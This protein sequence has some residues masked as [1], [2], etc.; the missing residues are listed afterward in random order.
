VR[1]G[2]LGTVRAV[3]REPFDVVLV[4]DAEDVRAVV[5]RQLRLSGRFDVVGVGGTGAEAIS[6]AGRHRPAVMVLDAS[7][8]DMDGLEALPGV[9]EASPDTKVVMLSGFTGPALETAA[10]A[11]GAVDFVE[12]AVPLRELPDRLLRLLGAT[13]SAEQSATAGDLDD[14]GA[15]EAVLAQ[16]LER[17]GTVFDQAAIGM[18]TMTLSGTVVRANAALAQL[19]GRPERALAG[20]QYAELAGSDD[21]GAALR[22]AVARLS[23]GEI[24]VAGTEH[25]L[26]GGTG[27]WVRST[28][29][30]VADPDGRPLYLFAQ[31]EDVTQRRRALEELQASEERFRL[32]VDSVTDY[33]IFMLDQEGLVTS[34]NA[35][36]ERMKGYRADEVIGQHFRIFYPPEQQAIGH[37]EH[38]LELTVRDGRYEEEGWRV[39]QDGTRFWAN[40][41]ITALF[42]PD[43]HLVGFGKVTRDMTERR[44]AEEQLRAA[45]DEA[46]NVVDITAHELH[47]PIAA[48]TGAA[49][50]LA[51]YWDRLEPDER[52][53][54]MRNLRSSAA[55]ARRLLDDLL[56]ASR[57]EAGSI[58]FQTGDLPL[59]AAIGE[60]IAAV[61]AAAGPVDVVGAAGVTVVADPTRL[62]QMLT[63]LL[64]NAARYGAAPVVVE[65]RPAGSAVEVRVCDHGPGIPDDLEPRLFRKFVRGKGRP[66]RG[67]GLGLFIVAEMARRQHGQV[68]YERR[69]GRTCFGFRLPSGR[70]ASAD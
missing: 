29:A 43:H 60:A 53:E 46:I 48:M 23:R 64:S 30:V 26:A 51:E 21:S 16:H 47:S 58:E 55:R 3:E 61:G 18:A 67:T 54:N 7:M 2:R 40:V 4:D 11:L 69:E 27:T 36:A 15:A 33:A 22:Q 42:D 66:D 49:D 28:L 5:S 19:T 65:V 13:P 35:G 39:R 45:K 59:E 57:L 38:E 56:T 50:I 25:P 41:V 31:A 70:S 12:K 44:M 24:D 6:L 10:R 63:N 62:V 68:W 37:P 8:P 14:G 17:F 52:A 9:L 1:Y 32:L 34:W 20:H